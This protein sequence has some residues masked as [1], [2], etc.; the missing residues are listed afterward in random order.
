MK[1]S[2]FCS[3]H[4]SFIVQ[5]KR[6]ERIQFFIGEERKL[7]PYESYDE[8]WRRCWGG[9]LDE[10]FIL[11]RIFSLNFSNEKIFSYSP[12]CLR[13]LSW[14]CLWMSLGKSF[15]NS[16]QFACARFRLVL[17]LSHLPWEIQSWKLFF[18]DWKLK[19]R[20]YC[21]WWFKFSI[22]STI[23]VLRSQFSIFFETNLNDVQC[24]FTKIYL[25]RQWDDTRRWSKMI[26]ISHTDS[27]VWYIKHSTHLN[28]IS[29]SLTVFLHIIYYMKID[30]NS[31]LQ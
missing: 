26:I 5:S 14:D 10:I 22:I 17:F 12:C 11:K 16:S 15:L 7:F 29:I 23:V 3:Y 25:T 28:R 21:V 20:I 8:E 4:K 18:M 1:N 2:R 31:R 6:M 27:I 24:H 19:F 13:S 30:E 9:D